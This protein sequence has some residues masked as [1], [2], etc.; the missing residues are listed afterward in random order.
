MSFQGK[1][2]SKYV[3]SSTKTDSCL[4]VINTNKIAFYFSFGG[5]N[6]ASKITGPK[7]RPSQS[8]SMRLLS[9]LHIHDDP[10]GKN[11]EILSMYSNLH[12]F[13]L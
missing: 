3:S 8:P 9:M 12:C 6:Q 4:V 2:V 11:I 10:E 7:R 1:N 5:V 13:K